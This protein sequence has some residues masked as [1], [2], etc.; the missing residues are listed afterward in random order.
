MNVSGHV[1]IAVCLC[2][3]ACVRACV[4]VCVCVRA[5]PHASVNAYYIHWTKKY[6][7]RS[8]ASVNTTA[9]LAHDEDFKL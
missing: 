6:F 3:R 9:A 7:R 2:V 8:N 4:R 5:P 1:Y